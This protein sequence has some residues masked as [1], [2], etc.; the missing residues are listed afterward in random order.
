M[1]HNYVP[2]ISNMTPDKTSYSNIK[3]NVTRHMVRTLIPLSINTNESENATVLVRC[4][5]TGTKYYTGISTTAIIQQHMSII[6]H[7]AS[8][9]IYVQATQT[10]HR[11]KFMYQ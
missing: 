3:Y 11:N 1:L 8:H 5:N 2:N 9:N 10:M 4:H 7:V 6:W